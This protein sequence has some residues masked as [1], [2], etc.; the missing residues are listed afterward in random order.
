MQKIYILFLSFCFFKITSGQT[1][2]TITA[3][4]DN[5]IYSM[6]TANSNGAGQYLFVGRNTSQN[7]SSIQRALIHFD[8]SQIPAGAVITSAT[9]SIYID[10]SAPS[11]ATGIELHKLTSAWGEGTSDAAGK[12]TSGAA[13]TANDATWSQRLFPS[14]NWTTAGG[15]YLAAISATAPSIAA[16][17]TSAT[18]VSM[19]NAALVTDIQQW[20][21]DPAS[22]FGWIM[23]SDN[24]VA[25]GSVKRIISKNSVTTSQV[26]SLTVTFSNSL[27]ITLKGFSGSLNK[28]SAL[29]KWSTATELDN[30]YFEIEHSVNGKDFLSIAKVKANGSGTTE[31]SYTY[32]D[33]NISIGKHFY[34]IADVDKNG[35]KRYSQV[36]TLS[37]GMTSVLQ[38]YPNPAVSFIS[39]AASSL[40]EGNEFTISSAIGQRMLKGVISKQQIDVQNLAPGNYFFSIKTKDGELI[41]S[42]FVKK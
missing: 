29:L 37:A 35:N 34:R 6:F 1:T 39:V 12:E 11:A 25:E 19:T 30:E 41:K 16:S 10:R 2:R 7:Q 8:L 38:L 24:E 21:S 28:Q 23:K 40:L 31:R 27:P 9:L 18:L 42:Q 15:D 32:V 14:S 3:D 17:I 22:N 26:P 33:E 4:R 5:T 13:A 36:I 20:I